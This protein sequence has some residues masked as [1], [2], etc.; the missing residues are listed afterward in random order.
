MVF[1]ENGDLPDGKLDDLHRKNFLN[2]NLDWNVLEPALR[3]AVNALRSQQ[4][5]V[6]I[7]QPED[8][9]LPER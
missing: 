9:V 8:K 3:K 7:Q 2:F 4:A 1:Y 6:S 5:V